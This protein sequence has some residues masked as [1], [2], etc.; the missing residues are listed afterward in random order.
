[1]PR[2]KSEDK[3]SVGLKCL[4]AKVDLP[5]LVAP[6]IFDISYDGTRTV[7]L[8]SEQRPTKEETEDVFNFAT[9]SV[10]LIESLDEDIRR[11]CES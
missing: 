3:T 9:N 8:K 10:V 1:M 11:A 7:R 2:Q 4:R 6:I 5:L